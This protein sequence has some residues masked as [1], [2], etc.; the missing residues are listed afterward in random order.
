MK[1]NRTLRA[2]ALALFCALAGVCGVAAVAHGFA[3]ATLKALVARPEVKVSLAG[4][5]ARDGK[6]IALDKTSAVHPGEV[7][8]WTITSANDGDG[9]AR[10]Y[11]AVG[12]I[13]QGTLLVAGCTV[14]DGAVSVTYSID[15][16]QTFS[17]QPTIEERQPDGTVKRVSAPIAIYTQVCY[18]WSD[19]LAAGG[20]LNASYKVRVK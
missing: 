18:E 12:Q 14:A 8:N 7:L 9:A 2:G 1:K 11:K 20:K 17:A 4:T 6:V 15:G 13:P 3:G 16:G 5:V 19:A 10:G